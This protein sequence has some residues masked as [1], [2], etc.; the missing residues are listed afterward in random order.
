MGNATKE[1]LV[2]GCMIP[3]SGIGIRLTKQEAPLHGRAK[4]VMEKEKVSIKEKEKIA[5][6]KERVV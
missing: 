1:S 4:V 2:L 3:T 5:K 6:E